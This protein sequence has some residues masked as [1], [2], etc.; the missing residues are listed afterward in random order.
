MEIISDENKAYGDYAVYDVQKEKINITGKPHWELGNS[1]GQSETLVLFPQSREVY[2]LNEVEMFMPSHAM[3]NLQIFGV[4]TNS[5]AQTN[6]SSTVKIS[7][8]IFSHQDKVSVFQD[9]V[10]V[11]DERGKLECDRITVYSGASNQVQK[12]VAD[13]NV[14][15]SQMD[16]LATGDQ[17]VYDVLQGIIYLTGDPVIKSPGRTAEAGAFIINRNQNTFSVLPGKFHIKMEPKR[18]ERIATKP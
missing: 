7:A 18:K 9:K 10:Q 6:K 4:S 17:A 13:K 2:A 5:A 8:E 16:I 3:G 11:V 1:H 14:M 15:I 12:V